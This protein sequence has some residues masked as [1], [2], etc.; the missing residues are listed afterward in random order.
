MITGTEN[1]KDHT[2]PR[3]DTAKATR[4]P[5]FVTRFFCPGS[6]SEL[7]NPKGER[8]MNQAIR[9][10]LVVI[11]LGLLLAGCNAAH[12]TEFRPAPVRTAARPVAFHSSSPIERNVPAGE[13]G[14]ALTANKLPSGA[15]ATGSRYD[16]TLA[17][18]RGHLQ[19]N[20][21]VI[22]D[23]RE[24][25]DFAQSHVRGALNMPAEQKEAYIGDINRDVAT[26]QFIIIY[27]GGPEC[28]AGD[29]VY[30][31]AASQGFSNMRIF[32]PGW[33]T[34]ASSHDLQ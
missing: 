11:P 31:Y 6:I 1:T 29:M 2:T 12:R 15:I 10:A 13:A 9:R 25:E 27:C 24:P 30:D 19:N 23:A 33:Q 28:S 32:K 5:H 17:E 8:S 3:T 7:S 20:T 21:A 26:S 18:F 4:E 16:I 34:L 22:I 14:F